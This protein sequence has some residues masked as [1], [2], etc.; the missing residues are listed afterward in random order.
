MVGVKLGTL[1]PRRSRR[2][3]R[4]RPV[5]VMKFGGTSVG[6]PE[7]VQRLIEIVLEASA[8]HT[9][10]VVVSAASGVTDRL[11]SAWDDGK[12]QPGAADALRRKLLDRYLT[13]AKALIT[14]SALRDYRL[15]MVRQLSGLERILAGRA[16][17]DGACRD[18]LLALGERLSVP[19]IA[20]ALREAGVQ[21]EPV[22]AASLICTDATH[23]DAAVDLARTER[24]IRRQF[25]KLDSGVVAVV[26]G[27]I[28]SGPDGRVTTLGRGG[29][30]YS[31]A[32]LAAALRAEKLE[33][34]TDVDG[35]Y[36]ED[37]RKNQNAKRLACI[38]LE[39]AWS[40]NQA[41]RLGMHR[42]ALDPL[43]VAGIPVHV[44]STGEP[45]HPGTLILPAEHELARRAVNE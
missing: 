42:K 45:D 18:E 43:V 3:T 10:V 35:I 26:P 39:E 8:T 2:I 40:W 32:L 27:F 19:L 25:R 17:E 23:G 29:S 13:L 9:P 1:L 36:T 33:R 4:S 14:P 28:G 21:T 34:W 44:R 30:D 16:R 12:A 20:A 15:S 38:V 7:R 22:D 24:Q 37:P 31:A 6:S 5:K 11:V 41:G